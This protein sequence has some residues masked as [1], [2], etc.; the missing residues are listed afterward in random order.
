VPVVIPVM[1]AITIAVMV[2]VVATPLP[3]SPLIVFIQLPVI[4]MWV[5]VIFH[6]PLLIVD[7]LVVI[8]AVIVVVIR[9]VRAIGVMFGTAN[10]GQ[11]Q[12]EHEWGKQQTSMFL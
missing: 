7:P 11:R 10:R 1:V 4:A 6:Y 8:P 9:I 2:A 3:V 12:Q 5:T